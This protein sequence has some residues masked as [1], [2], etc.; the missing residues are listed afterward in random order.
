MPA[1]LQSQYELSDLILGFADGLTVGPALA[2]GM[3]AGKASRTAILLATVSDM[4]AGAISMG[5]AQGLSID[6]V[7]VREHRAVS[8]GLRTGL[9]YLLG[10]SI[11]L[12][13]FLITDDLDRAALYTL[14]GTL[15]F[16]LAFGYARGRVMR[17]NIGTSI[18]KVVVVGI[19]AMSATYFVQ[20][21]ITIP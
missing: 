3:Y 8:S 13:A 14:V 7:R 2:L 11:P 20:R 15:G 5:M 18:A 12:W 16:M 17:E 6:S 9:G 19:A 1:T 21:L 4:I 10:S